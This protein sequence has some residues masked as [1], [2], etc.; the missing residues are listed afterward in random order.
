MY[1]AVFFQ[2]TFKLLI[3]KKKKKRNSLKNEMAFIDQNIIESCLRWFGHVQRRV[4][5]ATIRK[6]GLIQVKGMKKM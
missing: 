6:S 4:I 5:N 2:Y 1:G 3:K